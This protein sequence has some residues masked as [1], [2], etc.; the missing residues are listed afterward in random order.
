MEKCILLHR[1]NGATAMVLPR[2][3]KGI[4]PHASGTEVTVG[5]T[6]T[7]DK[8]IVVDES[9]LDIRTKMAKVVP[10]TVQAV[11]FVA[12]SGDM[13]LYDFTFSG[14]VAVAPW[15]SGNVDWSFQLDLQPFFQWSMWARPAAYWE[16][17]PPYTARI[18]FQGVEPGTPWPYEISSGVMCVSGIAFPQSGI[19]EPGY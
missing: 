17:R 10:P 9:E 12:T 4:Q 8:V 2:L 16:S 19:A 5:L 15:A 14:P 1:I 6:L 18:G 11:E 13:R 3:I 7:G